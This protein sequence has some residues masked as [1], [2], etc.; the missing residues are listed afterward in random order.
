[1][2]KLKSILENELSF[3]Q[4]ARFIIITLLI[5]VIGAFTILFLEQNQKDKQHKE[6]APIIENEQS[7]KLFD[8][9]YDYIFELRLNYPDIVMAQCIEESGSFTSKL[10][11]EGHNCF[12]MKVPSTRPTLAVGTMMGHAR[13]KSWKDCIIDYAIWQST[14]CR[15]LTRDEY[16]AYLDRIYA[17]KQGYS[18]RLKKI[19]LSK[20]L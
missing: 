18:E 4:I 17:E 11:I 16:F 20:G 1:M 10:F 6:V 19:I 2:K 13:F 14:F 5:V 7:I 8:E 9:V 15:R 12:G 3:D